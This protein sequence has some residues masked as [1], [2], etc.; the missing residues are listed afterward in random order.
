[1]KYDV[2]KQL[3]LKDVYL[4]RWYLISFF[5]VTTFGAPIYV[6]FVEPF[7]PGLPN[8]IVPALLYMP[9]IMLM[10]LVQVTIMVPKLDQSRVFEMS[11]PLSPGDYFLAKAIFNILPYITLWLISFFFG[12]LLGPYPEKLDAILL[13]SLLLFVA[14]CFL[15]MSV[16][17]FGFSPLKSLLL[18]Y[19]GILGV[20]GVIVGILYIENKVPGGLPL[21][22][23]IV[24]ALTE[25]GLA[26]L[27][28]HTTIKRGYRLRELELISKKAWYQMVHVSK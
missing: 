16:M 2:I 3:I 11:L 1:M 15:V 7:F 5:A 14:H 19:I 8:I 10:A 13:I 28:I 27:I 6:S 17:Y 21:L 20:I 12:M 25:V 9:Q 26:V 23:T 24:S 18:G 4:L 22:V